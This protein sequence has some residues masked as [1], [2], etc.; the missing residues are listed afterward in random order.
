MRKLT[1][2]AYSCLQLVFSTRSM[3]INFRIFSRPLIF[4]SL[5]DKHALCYS[6]FSFEAEMKWPNVRKSA[7]IRLTLSGIGIQRITVEMTCYFNCGSG[8][9]SETLRYAVI[10]VWVLVDYLAC[11]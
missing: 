5:N 10:P 6:L 3:V 7:F 4:I 8:S 11:H 1:P 2:C 9:I